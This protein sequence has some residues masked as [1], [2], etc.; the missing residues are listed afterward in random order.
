MDRTA[1]LIAGFSLVVYLLLILLGGF[2]FIYDE[3]AYAMMVKEFSANP[4]MVMPTI[5]GEHVEWKPPLFTW[6]YSAFYI[7]LKG[8]PLAPEL[9]FR[10]PSA[11]FGAANVLLVFL[12]AN[13]MYGRNVAIAAELLF[14]TSPLAFFSSA[15]IMMEAFSLFLALAAIYLY[16]TDRLLPGAFFLGLLTL[17]KWL[18]VIA[19]I[20]F[21]TLYF[22]KDK[23]L[24][25]IVLSFVSIPIA[26]G[27]YLL[28]AWQ[29]GSFQ[30]AS[31]SLAF[32]LSKPLPGFDFRYTLFFFMT[33]LMATFPLSII[34]AYFS[35]FARFDRW[36]D[37]SVIALGALAFLLPL[38]SQFLF[39][40]V[41]LAAPALAIFAS[42]RLDELGERRLFQAM[43][44]I[45]LL[46]NL[47]S[48]VSFSILALDP[49]YDL[50]QVTEFM[51]NKTVY[52]YEPGKLML[53]WEV[54]NERYLRTDKARLLLEQRN[55][56]ILF[57]RFNDS[58]D[59]QNLLPEFAG[60][61]PPCS[62]YL[63]VHKRSLYV[64]YNVTAPS[65]FRKLWETRN[66][67][68]YEAG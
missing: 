41:L 30:N 6:V 16:I 15:F 49:D 17:T 26:L 65:C 35:L 22:I 67:V 8:L 31:A 68:I 59:Y 54:I 58:D 21:V 57:Y 32:D 43:L 34:F 2:P 48:Y 23:K 24:P 50:R 64:L 28:L 18:Y 13:R 1:L 14:L 45:L 56:G 19:P 63:V 36:K 10:L 61:V 55:P 44:S 25:A 53:N 38:S 62:G 33:M 42:R 4:A 29:F 46:A 20:L 5:T 3:G 27:F 40:Y 51:K 7:P 52:F 12:I 47:V 37:R 11:L 60:S 39:W 9:L 66:Y